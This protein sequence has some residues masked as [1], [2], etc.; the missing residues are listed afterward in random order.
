IGE[1]ILDFFFDTNEYYEEWH[2][3]IKEKDGWIIAV[4]FREHVI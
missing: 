3:D 4:N 1:N 2:E